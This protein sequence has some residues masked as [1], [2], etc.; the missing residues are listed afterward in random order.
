MI[1][2]ALPG[3]TGEITYRTGTLAVTPTEHIGKDPSTNHVPKNL[4]GVILAFVLSS[5]L[6]LASLFL[7]PP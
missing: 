1:T 2:V 6:V 7:S 5:L 4:R 3:G